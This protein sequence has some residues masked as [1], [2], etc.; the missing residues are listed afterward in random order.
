MFNMKKFICSVKLSHIIEAENKDQACEEF[1]G[2]Y[3][4]GDLYPDCKE[5][6]GDKKHGKKF[7]KRK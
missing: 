2:Y 4:I 1:M 6:K 7:K 3:D 5:M